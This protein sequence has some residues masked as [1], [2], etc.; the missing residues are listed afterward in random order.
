M[1]EGGVVIG[2][3]TMRASGASGISFATP[4]SSTDIDELLRLG[5]LQ[6]PFLGI[7]LLEMDQSLID[8]CFAAP[9]RRSQAASAHRH[10][11]TVGCGVYVR[12]VVQH[13]PAAKSGLQ[14]GDIITDVNGAAVTTASDVLQQVGTDIGT[15]LTVTFVRMDT[16]TGLLKTL[17]A[18]AV[19]TGEGK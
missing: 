4:V 17:T 1:A 13:S 9:L 14:P 8:E 19:T 11:I 3:N 10:R 15:Q 2:V 18:T 7:N 16:K 6:R 12:D 5:K